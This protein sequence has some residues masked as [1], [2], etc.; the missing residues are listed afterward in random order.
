MTVSSTDDAR[1]LNPPP[2]L[3][4]R[5]GRGTGCS[6]HSDRSN[7]P[8]DS[9]SLDAST[10]EFIGAATSALLAQRSFRTEQLRQL[11][12]LPPDA[13]ADPARIEVNLV[14]RVAARSALHAIDAALRRIQQGNYGR[15]LRCDDMMSMSRLRAL[16]MASL[17]GRCQRAHNQGVRAD[18]AGLP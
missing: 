9:P 2:R 4:S 14:L 8:G 11:D 6:G 17:C 15:C 12:A 5:G 7:P 1:S 16:P 10:S 3:R 18:E 13:D